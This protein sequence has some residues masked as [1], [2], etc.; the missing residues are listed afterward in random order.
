[1]QIVTT[2]IVAVVKTVAMFNIDDGDNIFDIKQD[3]HDSRFAT[4][5]EQSNLDFK[6]EKYFDHN[7]QALNENEIESMKSEDA[8][9]ALNKLKIKLQRRHRPFGSIGTAFY[10]QNF[11]FN[12][13][14][15]VNSSSLKRNLFNQNNSMLTYNEGSE[16][17][18]L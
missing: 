4:S 10:R 18:Q 1:M 12:A 6:T 17:K 3:Y 2:V 9:D 11:G 8:D 5:N 16:L 15:C 7:K 14:A 13:Y